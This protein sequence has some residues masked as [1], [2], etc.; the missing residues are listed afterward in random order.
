MKNLHT[1]ANLHICKIYSRKLVSKSMHV[2]CILEVL[3]RCIGGG[4]GGTAVKLSA[5]GFPDNIG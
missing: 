5:L 3:V 2:N 1:S 4:L